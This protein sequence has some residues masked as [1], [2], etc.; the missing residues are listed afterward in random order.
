M[1]DRRDPSYTYQ[2][3]PLQMDGITMAVLGVAA[4]A[5]LK[6]YLWVQAGETWKAVL[7]G[8]GVA[9][10]LALGGWAWHRFKKARKRVFDPILIKEK[11]SRIAF[12]AEIQVT[13]I[14]PGN[15]RPHRANELLEPVAA[16]YR[17][18][19][20]P[21]GARFKASR[22][23]PAVPDPQVLHPSG[24]GLFGKHSVLGVREAACLWHPPGARDETPLVA[25]AGAKVLLPTARSVSGDTT[26]RTPRK[27][28]FPPDLLRRHHLYVARTR[29]GKS[30]L[31]HHIV[32]HKMR[33][34]AKGRDGDAIVVVDHHAD[35]VGG[36]LQH[37]PDSLV[38]QVRLIDLADERGAPGVNLLDT[39]IFSDRDR[40]ADS[41]VRIAK[42]LWG[43]WGPRMQ[44]ILEQTVKTLH[45]ANES[46]DAGEQYTIL[47]GLRILADE[48][49][50]AEVLAKVND[51]YLLQWWA[52]DFFGW[53]RETRADA[54]APV[55]TRLSYY[56]S[57]KRA[58]AILGQPRSTI[59]MRRVVQDGGIL[60]VSTAQGKAG[61]DV[62]ALVGASLLNLV[63]AVIREQ[64]SLPFEQRRG[65][66]VVVDEMQSMPGVDYESMLSE[67]GKFGA[68]FI[69]ITQ[70]LAKLDDLSRTMRD[71]LLANVGYLAVFQV[72]GNDARQLV[73]ELGKERVT[74]DDITSLPV[75][76]CYVRATVGTER[77]DAF[78]MRVA[79]PEPGDAGTAERI[80]ARAESY[81]TPAS[82]IDRRDA[83]MQDLVDRYR[84]ELEKLRKGQDTQTAESGGQSQEQARRKQ[85]SKREGAAED[86]DEETADGM[87]DEEVEE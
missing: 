46:R 75:H 7:M 8:A 74:E 25:R 86:S 53:R 19:D 61:R 63:D 56:A 79:K 71:T 34:K 3:K 32:A 72:A 62:A 13:A 11:V 16:A 38:E 6:G 23:R 18:Y 31:M 42:G 10:A 1:E 65:A 41:V 43:Q 58:R 80:I 69:L 21:A 48:D 24:P 83:D 85:R 51:P 29:M 55:Q 82:D 44:S 78:S 39:R 27:I 4:L 81:L 57:S 49:F 9:F 64:G 33:E 26:T 47:D 76:Q 40:T 77:M 2:T 30:T 17:D 66:L 37:V 15:T 14:L 73:W 20:N 36:L 22:V 35:L 67:L 5:A 28:H 59:D 45:E 52:R 60:L 87:A 84:E 70:S 68:S 54:L 50:K 12:D